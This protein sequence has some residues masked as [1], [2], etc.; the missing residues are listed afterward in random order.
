[1]KKFYSFLLAA[2]TIASSAIAGNRVPELTVKTL[3]LEVKNIQNSIQDL[4]KISSHKAPAAQADATAQYPQDLEDVSALFNFSLIEQD[5]T[6]PISTIV[7][8]TD[9]SEISSEDGTVTIVYTMSSF[10]EGVYKPDIISTHPVEVYYYPEDGIL[11]LP[12]YQAYL[13]YQASDYNLWCSYSEYEGTAFCPN[14]LFE[15]NTTTGSFDLINP[16]PAYTSKDQTEPEICTIDVLYIATAVDNSLSAIIA[17][18]ADNFYLTPL[19]ALGTMTYNCELATGTQ[20]YEVTVGAN[21]NENTLTIYNFGNG[22]CDVPMTIDAAAKTLTANKVQIPGV[23]EFKAYLS[24]ADANGNNAAGNRKYV[25]TSTYNVADGK[26]NITVPSWNAFYYEMGAG[27]LACLYPMDNTS[28][29]LD[30][31]LDAVASAGINNI[32]AD[33]IDVNAPIEYY[34]LQGIRVATPEAGQLLIKRQGNNASKV[35]IR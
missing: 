2:A 7:T 24:A 15:Y 35:V 4:T 22:L 11:V 28:I 10:F 16:M 18:D 9:G 23:T 27:D 5:G 32:A 34:N 12:G 6:Y 26:T 29:V 31:D 3:D 8:F 19:E 20:E 1:M 21:V 33:A 14:Y 13:T 30:F 17:L 25:L